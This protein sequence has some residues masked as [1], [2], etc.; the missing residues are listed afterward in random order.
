MPTIDECYRVLGLNAGATA[1]D[2][3]AA[4]RQLAK[5]WHP[6]RFCDDLKLQRRA[7]D[8]LARINEAYETIVAATRPSHEEARQSQQEWGGAPASAPHNTKKTHESYTFHSKPSA[9]Q[10]PFVTDLVDGETVEIVDVRSDDSYHAQKASIV[11]M[12]TTVRSPIHRGGGWYCMHATLRSLRADLPS[13][14]DGSVLFGYVRVR[15]LTEA[16]QG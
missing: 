11:G 9:S 7:N 6:D 13:S 3:R 14:I 5:V 12:T 1:E 4:R 2:V 10:A 15:R 16:R 8:E